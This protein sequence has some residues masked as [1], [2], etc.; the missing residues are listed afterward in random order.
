MSELITAAMKERNPKRS[1]WLWDLRFI[2]SFGPQE[3]K[4]LMKVW[5]LEKQ[6]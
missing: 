1:P 4:D 3:S 2:V 5:R 6:I